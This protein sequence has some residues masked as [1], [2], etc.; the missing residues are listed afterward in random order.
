MDMIKA[1]F[2][3]VF[4]PERIVFYSG[5]LLHI[6]LSLAVIFIFYKLFSL[7]F[8]RTLGKYMKNEH[9][10]VVA[11]LIRSSLRYVTF[12]IMLV[13]VLQQIDVNVTALLA[14]ASILGLAISFG[15]QNLIRDVISG[16]FIILENQYTVG[17]KV[18]ISGITGFVERMS[19]RL[20]VIRGE[21]GTIFTVPNGNISV[22][23]NFSREI[24]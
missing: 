18:Q 8:D 16:I 4:A 23:A 7:A 13:T 24:K 20:T 12:F 2:E 3:L 21:D 9:L 17:D 11:S 10:A 15:S 6:V 22:V 14:S 19:L 5:R 1:S